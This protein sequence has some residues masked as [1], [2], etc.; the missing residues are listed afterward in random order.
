MPYRYIL[1]HIIIYF[2]NFEL[3][4]HFQINLPLKIYNFFLEIFIIILIIL[5]NKKTYLIF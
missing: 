3:K 5:V 4:K 2:K 1:K